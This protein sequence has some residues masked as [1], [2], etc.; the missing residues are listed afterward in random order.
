MKKRGALCL[1]GWFFDPQEDLG[2]ANCHV[3]IV[4]GFVSVDHNMPILWDR[5]AEK[6]AKRQ[7]NVFISEQNQCMVARLVKNIESPRLRLQI[8]VST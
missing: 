4:S 7:L 3:D 5:H 2:S 1:S 6:E 8:S